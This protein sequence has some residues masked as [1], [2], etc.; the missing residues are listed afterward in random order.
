MRHDAPNA[1]LKREQVVPPARSLIARVVRRSLRPIRRSLLAAEAIGWSLAARRLLATR[2]AEETLGL[3]DRLPRRQSAQP[4]RALPP[5]RPFRFA[6]A[7][8]GRSLARSQY[9]RARGQRHTLIIG[10]RGGL[11][12]FGAHAWLEGDPVLPDFIEL[13]RIDR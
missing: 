10:V 4:A 8:L 9:L 5:E 1:Q 13:R 3:L 7:C 11:V 2:S 12:D 6:G